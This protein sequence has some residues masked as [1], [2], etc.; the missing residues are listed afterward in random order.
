[1]K[2]AYIYKPIY[3]L[4]A[5]VEKPVLDS[6]PRLNTNLGS[7]LVCL[8]YYGSTFSRYT[9]FSHLWLPQHSKIIVMQ[10]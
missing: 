3:L 7:K 2:I 10:Q 5:A 9:K 1:M 6:E 8:V 4:A